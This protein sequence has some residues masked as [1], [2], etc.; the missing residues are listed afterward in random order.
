MFLSFEKKYLDMPLSH[1]FVSLY[2]GKT[3]LMIASGLLGLFL[4]IFLYNLFEQDIRSVAVYYFIG[5]IIYAFFVVTGAQILSRIGFRRALRASV[6]FG[7]LFYFIF[8]FIDSGNTSYLI[9]FS[10]LALT[11]F[12]MLYWL[13]YH[14]DFAKFTSRKNRAR[15]VSIFNATRLIVGVF[16]P[17]IA[18]F[19][20]SSLG[21][22]V[23]FIVA[24][25]LI[26]ASGIPYITIPR[27][28]ERFSWS[29]FE[30]WRQFLSKERRADALAYIA[31]GAENTVSLV[32]W[33]IFI[34]QLL[35]GN[36]LHVG[37]VSTLII[38]ATLVLQLGVGKRIDLKTTKEKVLHWGTFFYSL[39]WIIKIFISTALQIF[40]VG[41][42][43][44]IA[45]IFT[46]TPFD[47][48]TYEIAADHKHLVDEFTV[49]H[50][51]AINFGR[52]LML[53]AIM[54]VSLFL[55]IQWIFI[56]AAIATIAMN[57]LRSRSRKPM[58]H[59]IHA[60]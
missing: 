25:V 17:L 21:F 41:A 59:H 48:L 49:L 32:V 11:L 53:V 14:V 9:P 36:Y 30:T 12:R 55:E 40:I 42:Y 19:I 16:I 18:G 28:K 4:P 39:G 60:L 37:L 23:L 22:D 45:Y 3:I 13:P 54:A 46:R 58:I 56:L 27:T 26:L 24:I 15:Q 52:S 1:G 5:H 43:H 47:A 38:G 29:F 57:L 2:T 10:I 44:N 51:M 33:P 34:F 50:E 31:D 6:F 35:E 20:V 8:Y 7:A